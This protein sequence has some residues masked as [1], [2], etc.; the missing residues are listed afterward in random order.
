[1]QNRYLGLREGSFSLQVYLVERY[2]FLFTESKSS[3]SLVTPRMQG[4]KTITFA[5]QLYFAAFEN[6]YLRFDNL[7]LILIN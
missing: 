3:F 1:M 5:G 2:S 4:D 7:K 6:W